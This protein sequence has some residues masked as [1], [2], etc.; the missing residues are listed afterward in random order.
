[1]QNRT[2]VRSLYQRIGV[3]ILRYIIPGNIIRNRNAV[4]PDTPRHITVHG[5]I[6]P[7]RQLKRRI[8]C[9]PRFLARILPGRIVDRPDNSFI[10]QVAPLFNLCLRLRAFQLR[11]P[12]QKF[13]SV[14][15]LDQRPILNQLLFRHPVIIDI[16]KYNACKGDDIGKFFVSSALDNMVISQAANTAQHKI[17]HHLNLHI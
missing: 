5:I 6:D 9:N 12:E 10:P 15:K 13:F 3:R 17:S 16:T 4:Y 11:I 8:R 1:M 7:V 14:L 2:A